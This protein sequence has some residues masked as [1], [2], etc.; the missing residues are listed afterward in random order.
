MTKFKGWRVGL[1]TNEAPLA[2]ATG[3]PFAKPSAPVAHG[4]LRVTLWQTGTLG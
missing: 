4:S 3:L 1:I 2:Y